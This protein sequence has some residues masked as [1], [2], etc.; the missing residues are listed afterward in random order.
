MHVQKKLLKKLHGGLRCG[1]LYPSAYYVY[2]SPYQWLDNS[3]EAITLRDSKGEEIDK[4]LVVSD[5]ENDNR[6]WMRNNSE[7]IFG[8]KELEKGKIGSVRPIL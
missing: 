5:N 2:T 6:Y 4:T 3:E 7:W 1:T 8:V